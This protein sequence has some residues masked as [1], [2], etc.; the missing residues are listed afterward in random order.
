MASTVV[1]GLL[2]GCRD[3]GAAADESGGSDTD[4]GSDA[5]DD[6]GGSGGDDTGGSPAACGDTL[7]VGGAP[8]RRLTHWEFDNTIRDLLGDD[9]RYGEA[10]PNETSET[11]FDNQAAALGVGALL[12]ED[13]MRAAEAVAAVAITDLDA[14]LTCYPGAIGEDPCALEWIEEFGARAYRRPLTTAQRDRLFA[15]YEATK[16]DHGFAGG[17]ELT[18]Q[19]MLQSPYF[20]YRVE[21]GLPDPAGEGV[22]ALDDWEIASRLSYLLWGSMPDDA[23]FEAAEAGELADADGIAAQAERM[24]ADDRARDVVATFHRQWLRLD[25]VDTMSKDP[26]LFPEFDDALRGSMKASTEA[27]IDHVVF[28]GEGDLGTLLTASYGFADDAMAGLLGIAAPGSSTPVYVELPA[29]E[30]A[31]LLT[32]PSV[33]ASTAKANQTSPVSRGAFVQARLMCTTLPEPPPDVD[34][35]PPEVDQD[36]TTRERFEQHSSDP[37]CAGC[38][39]LIDPVGFGLEHY[40][41]LGRYRN[42]E[43]GMPVDASGTLPGGDNG[44]IDFDGAVELS[45]ALAD[46][47]QVRDCFVQQWFTYAHGRAP[48]PEDSCSVETLQL[49]FESADDDVRALLVALTRTDAFRYRPAIGGGQ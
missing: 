7:V 41:A 28:D 25:D 9:A 19:A 5:A 13:Y 15:L 24:L 31:G 22:V 46:E 2:V 23:L 3:D 12:A 21:E 30:R 47:A 32:Q 34:T 44:N 37:S 18:L 43:N 17:L 38:H 39:A 4:G 35:T 49:D 42:E 29:D 10:F 27:F 14:L 36:A 45:V 48:E 8:L 40:D 11:S 6:D 20:L 26:V 33:L 1:L 16:A